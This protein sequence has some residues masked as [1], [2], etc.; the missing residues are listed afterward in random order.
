[1]T[2]QN[3]KPQISYDLGDQINSE[4]TSRDIGNQI[5]SE[6]SSIVDKYSEDYSKHP[7]FTLHF[8]SRN[9]GVPLIL[10]Q[11]DDKYTLYLGK[12]KTN[13]G[14]SKPIVYDP[15]SNEVSSLLD[16]YYHT[17]VFGEYANEL[18]GK[19]DKN[20]KWVFS[21]S[22]KGLAEKFNLEVPE[23]FPRPFKG[24]TPREFLKDYSGLYCLL[25]AEALQNGKQ[26]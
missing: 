5:E 24:E 19:N 18:R 25:V 8:L 6:F 3:F 20:S 23:T 1:M 15:L 9:F 10:V 26:Y 22:L 13:N 16:D 11:V 4:L 7:E 17:L 21:T 14:S 2:T 12:E